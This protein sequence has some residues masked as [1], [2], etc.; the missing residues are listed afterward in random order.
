MGNLIAAVFQRTA[1]ADNRYEYT[2]AQQHC[3]C[4][5]CVAAWRMLHIRHSH[6]SVYRQAWCSCYCCIYQSSY[7][8][9]SGGSTSPSSSTAA[10]LYALLHLPPFLAQSPPSTR[11]RRSGGTLGFVRSS[12]IIL[13]LLY[14]VQADFVHPAVESYTKKTTRRYVDI[15]CYC[16]REVVPVPL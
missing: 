7:I 4:T 5:H 14:C 12:R 9:T 3:C 13:L 1:A 16:S 6:F 10:T 8:Y 11:Q 15:C 2:T